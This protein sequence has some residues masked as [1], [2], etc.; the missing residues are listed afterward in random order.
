MSI[1][2]RIVINII[3]WCNHWLTCTKVYKL[4]DDVDDGDDCDDGDDDD[5]DDDYYYNHNY[6]HYM[7]KRNIFS[8]I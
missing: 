6:S 2:N 7:I 4:H 1:Y 8:H 3:Y 5:D